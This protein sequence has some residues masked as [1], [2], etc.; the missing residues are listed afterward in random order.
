MN[1]AGSQIAGVTLLMHAILIS[2]IAVAS[3]APAIVTMAGQTPHDPSI[4]FW[5]QT[6]EH[7][8]LKKFS[9]REELISFIDAA[10]RNWC[11]YWGEGVRTFPAIGFVAMNSPGSDSDYV[12][13]RINLPTDNPADYSTTNIQV[14]GVD[15]A[16]IVKCDGRYIYVVS[17]SKVLIIYA[18]PAEVARILSEIETS[19]SPTEI[20]VNGNKLVV[21]GQTFIKVYDISDRENPVLKRDVS[22]DGSY[23]NSRLIGDF[24]Y[25]IIN[26][27]ANYWD[28][29]VPLPEICH[30]G[31]TVTV[32]ATEI[33]YF[34]N[35][36]D[37]CYNFTTIMAINVQNDG[38]DIT[39]ATFLTGATK[40]IFVSLNNIY[41]TCSGRGW[42]PEKTIIHKISVAGR[43][44][45]YKCQG[46]VP[47]RVLN[48]FSMDE[49]QGYFRIATTTRW[50]RVNHVYILGED[51]SIVGRLENLAPGERIYSA[52]F[53]GTRAYLVTFKQVDP[54][55]VL[56]LSDPTNPR[57][58]GELKIP[59][60]SDYLHPY[61]ETHII[62]IGKDTIDAGSFA[63]MQ[64]V[65][66]SL[67]DVSDP[68]NPREISKYMIGD[69]GT[70]WG[71]SYALSDHRAFLFSRERNLLVVPIE[72]AER[73]S[74]D[75]SPWTYGIH[76]WQGAYVFNISLEE[77]FV[78]KGRITHSEA[79]F[80]DWGYNS[81][82]RYNVR[83][84]LYIDNVLYTIS[85]GLVKM[86]NLVDLSG[87]NEVNL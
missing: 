3:I 87:M 53:I 57:V 39:S 14:A 19:E 77:G 61:D 48:Q 7:T 15:E 4:V 9:S 55:F 36:C 37:Y 27:Y 35:V 45:E 80:K 10:Y 50:P 85:G 44:I 62:G 5:Q 12:R 11:C 70:E 38:A 49:Y 71:D 24:V 25:V 74:S 29:I 13:Y 43:A 23:F 56:D 54:L 78:L 79:G 73:E 31:K 41:L 58:L 67:F 81:D 66:L 83:R 22:F 65:K 2:S 75:T 20:F 59:G 6:S 64:G 63:W 8:G 46:E 84:S 68:E 18:Y 76:V 34:E 21:L 72:L 30:N 69:R 42:W 51:L 16:D 52:R 26:K 17:G 1:T 28:N 40:D 47:G 33:Y 32:P 60:Y 86:N 82:P